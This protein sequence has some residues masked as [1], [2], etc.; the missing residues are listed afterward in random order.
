[1]RYCILASGSKG[2]STFIETQY[3]R[4]L[5]DVGLSAK[6]IEDRLRK[7]DVD[8]QS[9]DSIVLTHAHTDHVRGAGQFAHKHKIP[10]YAHPE[11]LDEITPKLKQ[12]QR[13]EPWHTSF[14]IK[15]TSFTP[16]HLSHD[17]YPTFGYLIQ[18]NS[19][20]L[21]ICTDLG[22]VTENVKEHL[23]KANALILES[24]HDQKMLINGTYPWHLKE[25]IASRVGHLSNNEAGELL[26]QIYNGNIDKIILAHLSEDNNTSQ[27]AR[28]T[29]LEIVGNHL[30]LYIDVIEQRQ[31][32]ALFQ[33]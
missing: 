9:I 23:Q 19:K 26:L 5:V 11:T 4:I 1:M 8:P 27:L 15:D 21:A 20:T 33:L 7:L 22:V 24:N 17:C 6:K 16:F 13:I 10:I 2:N 14:Y 18:E 25:R 3:A 31:M 30:E 12:D 29:V 32:S 28:N